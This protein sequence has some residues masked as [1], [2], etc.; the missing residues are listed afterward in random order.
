MLPA[1]HFVRGH[2][3]RRCLHPATALLCPATTLLHLPHLDTPMRTP[4]PRPLGPL[5]PNKPTRPHLVRLQEVDHVLVA[6]RLRVDPRLG[7]LHRQRKGVHHH[8]RV[9]QHL[10]LHHAHHL[11]VPPRLG[12]HGHLEQGQRRD[13]HTAWRGA[14]ICGCLAAARRPPAA[15]CAPRDALIT[16]MPTHCLK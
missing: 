5:R 13:A 9:V 14:G 1:V 15:P 8:E 4:C 2:Q 7:A 6:L 10:A 3:E 12:V 11:D 16:R